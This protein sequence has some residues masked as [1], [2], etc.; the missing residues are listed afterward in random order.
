MDLASSSVQW[1]ALMPIL[2]PPETYGKQ[3]CV[4]TFPACQLGRHEP[5]EIS[6]ME[7]RTGKSFQAPGALHLGPPYLTHLQLF[8]GNTLL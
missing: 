1:P 5:E 4:S 2:S 8:P 6:R 7:P 3:G